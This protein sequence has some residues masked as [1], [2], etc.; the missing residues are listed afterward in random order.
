LV[1]S[2]DE[3]LVAACRAVETRYWRVANVSQFVTLDLEMAKSLN[4]THFLWDSLLDRFAVVKLELLL[5]N[6]FG[7]NLTRLHS[8]MEFS[9]ES[10][11]LL[12][13]AAGP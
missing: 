12:R 9:P 5:K 10:Q 1:P 2:L 11:A 8:R 7:L 4:P 13:D 3:L 6:P